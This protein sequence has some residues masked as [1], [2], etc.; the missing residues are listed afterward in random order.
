MLTILCLLVS[1]FVISNR[2]VFRTPPKEEASI[3]NAILLFGVI[4][5]AIY[6]LHQLRELENKSRDRLVQSIRDADEI[7]YALDQTNIVAITNVKGDITYVNDKFCKISK[8]SREELI[9]QNHRILKSDYHD[10]VFFKDLWRTIANGKIW[11]GEVKNLAKDGSHYWVD[12]SIVPILN[13]AGKPVEYLAIR[14]DITQKKKEERTNILLG[15]LVAEANEPIQIF[16]EN[17]DI[18]YANKFSLK[19]LGYKESEILTK[20]IIDIDQSIADPEVWQEIISQLEEEGELDVDSIRFNRNKISFPVILKL[21]LIKRDG[22]RFIT[23]NVRDLADF[24]EKQSLKEDKIIAEKEAQFKDDFLANMSHEIRTPL[25]GVIGML[26]ILRTTDLNEDQEDYVGTINHSSKLLLS[27][28]NDVL[29]L[30]KVQS[31][32]L[33]IVPKNFNVHSAIHASKGLYEGMAK[34]KGIDLLSTYADNVPGNIVA[35]ENRLVQILNNLTS[36]AIKFT[37]EGSVKIH[38]ELE[39]A[40]QIKIS[41]TDTGMGIPDHAI[42]KLFEKFYQ[43]KNGAV[44]KIKGTGLGLAICKELCQLMGGD[45]GVKSELGKGSTFWFTFTFKEGKEIVP[46]QIK[47]VKEIEQDLK[48][49]VLLVEDNKVNQKVAMIM[50]KMLGCTVEI[51]DNGQIGID[52]VTSTDDYDLI[53]MDIQMPVMGGVE[54]MK[55]LDLLKE[56]IVQQ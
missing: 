19:K 12:T 21:K 48:L 46:E 55:I 8:Y 1:H 36:N 39:K 9:G 29:D 13:E 47:V 42:E 2:F 18:I 49:K 50:L 45:I 3:G 17:G 10:E 14:K 37:E 7:K 34:E 32:K 30:S 53:L 35:D 4:I 11:R 33:D 5:L 15:E 44:N 24:Y 41:V 22:Q 27:I 6:I 56:I 51:A 38:V 52:M 26:E 43:V 31:G 40:N 16:N 54:A 23:C 20:N 28:I 25:N